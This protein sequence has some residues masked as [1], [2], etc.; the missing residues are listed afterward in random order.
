MLVSALAEATAVYNRR[1]TSS[2][3]RKARLTCQKGYD[4]IMIPRRTRRGLGH[5][6]G[7]E[8]PFTIELELKLPSTVC[9]CRLW[10]LLARVAAGAVLCILGASSDGG[11]SRGS[12]SIRVG[13]TR[14]PLLWHS[15]TGRNGGCQAGS[16]RLPVPWAARPSS[17]PPSV[18]PPT[19][20]PILP[21]AGFQFKP[22]M[23]ATIA[24]A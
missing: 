4:S 20:R 6:S 9:P 13:V 23:S 11:D 18:R 21:L 8:S 10:G 16:G 12:C 17:V 7:P 14:M 22:A 5:A 2:S 24:G 15:H 1:Y 3:R 19:P